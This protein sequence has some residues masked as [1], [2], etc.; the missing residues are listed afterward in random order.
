MPRTYPESLGDLA[1][2]QAILGT[3]L[4]HVG[5]QPVEDGAAI[6]HQRAD[7]R[8]GIARLIRRER[9][10]LARHLV[11][12][13]AERVDIGGAIGGGAIELLGCHV[14]GRA[15]VRNGGDQLAHREVDD[16]DAIREHDIGR[17][18]IVMHDAH[19]V[20][21]GQ[22]TRERMDRRDDLGRREASSLDLVGEGV[23]GD[24]LGD[25]E[26]L[27]A[28]QIGVVDLRDAERGNSRQRLGLGEH[29]VDRVELGELGVN[30][31][32]RDG[33]AAVDVLAAPDLAEAARADVG[34]DGEAADRSVEHAP[35]LALRAGTGWDSRT[36]R[37]ASAPAC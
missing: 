4:Q 33:V 2:R 6:R 12:E 22:R 29:R 1:H 30:D 7:A 11:G 19:A 9:R 21:G 32:D 25:H 34:A 26:R 35:T 23:T 37:R 31:L 36:S 15:S 10:T 8:R 3:R 14:C 17:F 28:K 20:R 13:T 24:E 5:D 18:E 16:H 27:A